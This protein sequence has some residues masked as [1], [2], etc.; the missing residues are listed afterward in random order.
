MIRHIMTYSADIAVFG[1]TDSLYFEYNSE[2]NV[3]DGSCVLVAE[4]GCMNQEALN[5]IQVQI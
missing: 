3:N 4:Y 2:A 1:C 5:L